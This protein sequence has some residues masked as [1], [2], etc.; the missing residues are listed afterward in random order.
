M[1]LSSV[2]A[3]GR[4]DARGWHFCVKSAI[5]KARQVEQQD[6]VALTFYWPVLERKIRIRGQ[7][8]QLIRR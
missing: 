4:P 1:S 8:L 3:Q 6:R 5:P 7:A 2:D